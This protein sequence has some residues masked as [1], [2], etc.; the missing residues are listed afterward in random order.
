MTAATY[1]L[2]GICANCN[3]ITGHDPR[4]PTLSQPGRTYICANC[5]GTGSQPTHRTDCHL[6]AAGY[7]GSHRR[8]VPDFR[9]ERAVRR[10][11]ELA[12]E[13]NAWLADPAHAKPVDLAAWSGAAVETLTEL[14]RNA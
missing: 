12:A 14:T 5:G 9:D 11:K 2:T 4:C 13:L 1:G 8:A 10:A 3:W 6:A 7:I